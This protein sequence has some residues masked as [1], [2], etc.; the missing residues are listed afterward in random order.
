M[1]DGFHLPAPRIGS[2]RKPVTEKNGRP[3]PLLSYVQG[4]AIC[5]DVIFLKEAIGAS[6]TAVHDNHL[7]HTPGIGIC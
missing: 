7:A 4:D 3:S 2:I 6:E 1:R 5:I